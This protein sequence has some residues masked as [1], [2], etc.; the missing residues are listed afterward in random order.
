LLP[1][2]LESTGEL[3]ITDEPA[4]VMINDSTKIPETIPEE[5]MQSDKNSLND[6]GAAVEEEN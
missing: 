2:L 1:N 6:S 3:D 5:V 4:K